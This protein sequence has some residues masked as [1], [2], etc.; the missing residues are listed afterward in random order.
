M[1]VCILYYRLT[2]DITHTAMSISVCIINDFIYLPREAID[3]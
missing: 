3:L 1:H 2:I